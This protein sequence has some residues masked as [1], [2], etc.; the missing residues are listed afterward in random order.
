MSN[1]F[2]A[3]H[4]FHSG[5][6][7]GDA[8][9][10]QMFAL[11]EV[12]QGMGFE[13]HIYSQH[14]DYDL[15]HIRHID[16]FVQSENELLLVHHSMGH[17]LLNQILGFV[18]PIVTV[19]HNITPARELD[20][21]GNKYFSHVGRH[22]LALLAQRSLAGI[23]D[24]NYNRKEMLLAGFKHVEIIPVRTNFREYEVAGQL[25]YPERDWLFVG[26]IAPNKGQLEIVRAFN[27][28]HH[29]VDK[30]ARLH[31]VGAH[32]MRSYVNSVGKEIENLNLTA[33]IDA[34]GKL[35]DIALINRYARAGVFVSLSRHEGF[36]VPLLEAMAAQVPVV[37]LASS[38][39]TETMG[40]AGVLIN[41]S[42]PHDVSRAVERVMTDS[43]YRNEV[44][45]RQNR[46]LE[47]ITTFNVANALHR[48]LQKLSGQT[49]A[50]RVQVQGP[51]E[52]SYSLAILN[53]EAA[54]QLDE[55]E[56]F[57][58]SVLPTEGPG[59]YPVDLD[60]IANIPGLPAL[61]ERGR[62]TSYPDVIIRQMFPPRVNDTT[63]QITLQYFGWEESLVPQEFASDFNQHVHRIMT[64]STFV[65][66]ALRN[67][68]VTI[69]I[70]VVGVGVRPPV[71]S[72]SADIPEL[73][74]LKKIRLLHISSAFPR[75][76]VDVLLNSYF[77]EFT[78]HDDVSLILKT[79]PNQHNTVEA[80][81]ENLNLQHPNAPH[82]VWINRDLPLDHLGNL[83]EVASAYV[84][85]ARG[86]GFGLPVAEAMLA[87]VPVIST[88][89]SGL[90]DFVDSSTAAVIPSERT[91][92][93]SHVSITGSEWFEPDTQT[94][95]LELR[96]L[97]KGSDVE[98]RSQR[99]DTAFLRI[100]SDFSW[101][102]VG[103]RIHKSV[104]ASLSESTSIKVSHLSTFNSRC[105]IAEYT[106]LLLNGLP[107]YVASSIYANRDAWPIDLHEE[108]DV[109]RIWEQARHQDV[110]NLVTAL[111]IS[112]SDIIHLQYNYGFFSME[113]LTM[114]I[115]HVQSVKPI[116]VTL[117][118]TIDLDRGHEIVSLAHA[119]EALK[120]VSAVVVHEEHDVH[121]LSQF[122]IADNVVLI[123]HGAMPFKGQRTGRIFNPG[124]ELKI[125]TF[126]FLLPHKGLEV[127]LAALH[128]LNS[129]GIPTSLTALCS[130]HPDPSSQATLN[131]VMDIMNGWVL[132]SKV[133]LDSGFK[134]VEE[135]HT[136]LDDVDILVLPYTETEESS[137]GVLAM[138]LG[139]GKPIIATDLA[140]FSGSKDALI[141]IPAP[142]Q[143]EDLTTAI[144]ELIS[145]PNMMREKGRT[146]AQRAR[147]I[148]WGAIGQ[149]TTDLYQSFLV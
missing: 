47:K 73:N 130:I 101:N 100:S 114:L 9:T 42:D 84:H 112:D 43:D 79:F 97:Y 146:A 29:N 28:Y 119:A 56:N 41:S 60:A 30:S 135:I 117:H 145:N 69:P 27:H 137:S 10:N 91:S 121:R 78:S 36:G 85:P 32:S 70:D 1:N 107:K 87:R 18:N 106:S 75:K 63:A 24:S 83:Y 80:Q 13:S 58:V 144:S 123:P 68:G 19:Y 92:A 16:S 125:G 61:F 71:S 127:T 118:R 134:T 86:E 45:W 104:E 34:P 50:I 62:S 17:H 148:S 14:I 139:I 98:A 51:I 128:S 72:P 108:E 94:L 126:G 53:R 115:N 15:L 138:L 6:S 4:Q 77:A 46:R 129:Q 44:L 74:A 54:F 31:L 37:A 105:G 59:D 35:D 110:S 7:E 25:R 136:E 66:E 103:Q 48:V 76:G 102:A 52:S 22:Q 149:K 88:A 113:D 3:V 21:A 96:K 142:A 140:I 141:T 55:I 116:V 12:L 109:V 99:I 57:N 93:A 133:R 82:V 20:D 90:A 49:H 132:T 8:I 2:S 95:Q 67:S 131:R 23:A 11:Q 26:R 38:A 122:G 124:A 64:M 40:G 89:T 147:D 39:V 120:K 33:Q 5:T 81:L 65:K 111:N 143:S